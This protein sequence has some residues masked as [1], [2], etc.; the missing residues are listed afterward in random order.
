MTQ[1]RALRH[2]SIT[3]FDFKEDLQL[4]R[5]GMRLPQQGGGHYLVPLT[6]SQPTSWQ[7]RAT[8]DPLPE[9]ADVPNLL[10]PV[11]LL[12]LK[13]DGSTQPLRAACWLYVFQ[14]GYLWREVRLPYGPMPLQ[15]DVNLS[16]HAG[17]DQRP[18]QCLGGENLVLPYRINGENPEY[19]LAFS[20]VQWSWQQIQAF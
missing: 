11:R 9:M 7:T 16:L 13:A 8:G 3:S 12:R 10:M 17:K 19:R 2:S 15:Q 4:H 6:A 5:P 20:E 14:N 18:A 1:I